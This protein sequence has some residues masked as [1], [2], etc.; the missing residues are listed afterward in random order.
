MKKKNETTVQNAVEAVNET[1]Q[2]ANEFASDANFEH[3]FLRDLLEKQLEDL[4]RRK[5]LADCRA[6][7]LAKKESLQNYREHVAADMGN[8]ETKYAKI[9]FIGMSEYGRDE[10]RINVNNPANIVRYIDV[11]IEDIDLAVA[12]IETEIMQPAEI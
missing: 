6:L 3:A 1:A 5:N 11:L 10:E 12:K 2:N 7:F 8:F 4:T 9:V